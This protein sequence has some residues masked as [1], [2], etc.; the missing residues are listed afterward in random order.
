M[1]L[2]GRNLLAVTPILFGSLAGCLALDLPTAPVPYSATTQ[3]APTVRFSAPPSNPV[4]TAEHYSAPA[5]PTPAPLPAL[6]AP[7]NFGTLAEL[8]ADDVV[9]EVLVHNPS[10]AQMAAAYQA[11]SAR[12]PQVTSFDDPVVGA[13]T[14]PGAWKSDTVGGGY[15]LDV[16]QRYPWPGKLELRGANAR[17]EASA[18]GQD[19]DDVRLQLVESARSAFYDYFFV[20]RALVV[21][22]EGLALLQEFRRNAES[23]YT[24]GLTPQQDV[25][26]ADVEIGRQRE[27]LLTLERMRQ[28]AIARINTLMHQSPDAALPPPPKKLPVDDRLHEPTALRC[29]ALARRPDLLALSNRVAADQASLALAQKDYKPDLEVM[30]GYDTFWQERPLRG[31]VG[32]RMNVPV[33]LARRDAAVTEAQARLAQRQ[34]ELARL[35]DQTN[36]EVQQAYAQVRESEQ[37][38]RLYQDTILPAAE[39]NIKAA[40]S[41]YVTNRIP[42]LSLVEAQRNLV[43]LRDRYYEAVAEFFRRRATL[44]RVSGGPLPD[45][46]P[47]H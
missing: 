33:R 38:V 35:T 21:N 45:A 23:R 4:Q 16:A 30:A 26:Q 47:V 34:A 13:G 17:A 32:V 15:R 12:Y 46:T 3:T 14:A 37:T 2:T 10:L 1:R 42:F 28:V 7:N 39:A 36:Y 18:A 29:A 25:L 24:T 44:E 11:A 6:T 20:G 40:Q 41:A 5:P 43:G 31:M 19:L 8:T 27:R 9:R 22:D